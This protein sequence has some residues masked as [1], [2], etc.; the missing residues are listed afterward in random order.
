MLSCEDR[1]QARR[2][3]VQRDDRGG[4][5]LDAARAAAVQQHHV[6]VLGADLVEGVPDGLVIVA[7]GAAGEGDAPL[8]WGEN[9]AS[10]R[11][12]GRAAR[13]RGEF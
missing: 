5:A 6:E 2:L 9:S 1:Q 7:I 3:G 11:R 12:R 10:T 4:D 8:G 13:T